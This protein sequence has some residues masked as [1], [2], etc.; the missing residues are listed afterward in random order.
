MDYNSYIKNLHKTEHLYLMRSN[1]KSV[2]LKNLDVFTKRKKIVFDK[3][4]IIQGD[5]KSGKTF[6]I[7]LIFDAYSGGKTMLEGFLPET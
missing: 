7:N 3:Y 5:K 2:E 4:N 1:V 6:L